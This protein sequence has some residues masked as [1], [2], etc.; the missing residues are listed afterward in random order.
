MITQNTLEDQIKYCYSLI[1]NIKSRQSVQ[2]NKAKTYR[3]G[4]SDPWGISVTGTAFDPVKQLWRVS[5]LPTHGGTPY[6]EFDL[7]VS[8]AVSLTHFAAVPDATAYTDRTTIMVWVYGYYSPIGAQAKVIARA[9]DTGK[10]TYER[11]I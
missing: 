11:V 6:T 9:L 1:N 2:A 5:F 3:T 4:A 7:Y 10:I 8:S